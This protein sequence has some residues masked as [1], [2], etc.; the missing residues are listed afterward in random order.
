MNLIW[1]PSDVRGKLA[2]IPEAGAMIPHFLPFIPGR[3]R[4][5]QAGGNVGVFPLLLAE[6]FEHVETYEPA[7]DNLDCL[8]QNLA[9]NPTKGRISWAW[10]PMS[11]VSGKPMRLKETE[12]DNCGAH[13]FQT[14][15]DDPGAVSTLALDDVPRDA[16]DAIWLDVEGAELPALRGA[17]KTIA[18][19]SPVIILEEKGHGKLFDWSPDDLHAFLADLGYS[20]RA[21]CHNDRL[22]KR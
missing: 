13:T 16:C 9:N 4:I 5:I 22:Y 1:P 21:R 14:V 2:I 7:S 10:H 11:D 20:E 17:I 18:A 15:E 19:F 6:H 3:K 8:R 12:P